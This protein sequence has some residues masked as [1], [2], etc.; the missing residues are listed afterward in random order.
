MK[1][2]DHRT[3]DDHITERLEALMPPSSVPR[4]PERFYEEESED[5]H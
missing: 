1:E 4:R 5:A 3:W 2:T